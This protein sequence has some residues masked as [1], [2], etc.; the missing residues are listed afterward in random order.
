M[1]T[2]L[3]TQGSDAEAFHVP[4][5]PPAD[6]ERWMNAA[7]S[8]ARA[9]VAASILMLG[10]VL[11]EARQDPAVTDADIE[12]SPVEAI[13]R[14]RAGTITALRR[15]GRSDV[16][17][18][19]GSGDEL[20]KVLERLEIPHSTLGPE[21]LARADLTGGKVLLINP[22]FTFSSLNYR[23]LDTSPM[24]KEIRTLEEKEA[25]LRKRV[26]ETDI[27]LAKL[28]TE[29]VARRQGLENVKEAALVGENV[30]KFVASGGYV[31]TNDWGISILERAFPGTVARGGRTGPIMMV[32]PKAHPRTKTA[33]LSEVL[34]EGSPP[35]QWTLSFQSYLI[36]IE[37]PAVEVLLETP[38]L[39]K[40]TSLAVVFSPDK[41][42]GKALHLLP[43]V[44]GQTG[45]TTKKA[46]YSL[47]NLLLN[48]IAER[49]VH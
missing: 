24:E 32:A 44:Y 10:S 21:E 40:L 23:V 7:P 20:E 46:E 1:V 9:L 48:F 18:V 17:V 36:R 11:A 3:S 25:A 26:P 2:L 8:W 12:Q 6:T 37:K 28:T 22:H 14:K 41:S 16:L 19:K 45:Q 29:L 27:D 43:H 47:L 35:L 38:D 39:P 42:K 33:L 49:L 15:G 4:Q 5:T 30:R 34:R 31:V 13:L